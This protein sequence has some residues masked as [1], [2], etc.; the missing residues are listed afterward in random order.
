MTES[1]ETGG[2]KAEIREAWMRISEHT[3]GLRR[4]TG[5]LI[6]LRESEAQRR[7]ADLVALEPVQERR[8]EA[9]LRDRRV[10]VGV[11][12]GD[13]P[14]VDPARLHAPHRQDLPVLERAQEQRLD[15]DR[16][17]ADLVEE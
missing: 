13:H 1:A 16:H 12:G 17:L 9:P 8:A 2:R 7:Q 10:E 14:H 3:E 5:E 15:L 4:I 6:D 11:G